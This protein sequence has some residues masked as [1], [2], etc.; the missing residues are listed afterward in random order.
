MSGILI[1]VDTRSDS[2]KQDLA[3]L[4]KNLA[5]LIRQAGR[6]QVALDKVQATGFKNVNKELS[7]GLKAF[8][9]FNTT[10]KRSLDATT[11]SSDNLASSL[12]TVRN[13]VLSMGAALAGLAGVSYFNRMAD[14]LTN[15]QNRLKLVTDGTDDLIRSQQR[16]YKLSVDTR[17]SFAGTANAFVDFTKSLEGTG[18]SQ[19]KVLSVV[20]T[21]QQASAL[22]GPLS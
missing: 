11:K 10:G 5:T 6:S 15:V 17:A 12:S 1:D 13:L 21:I 14:D 16:L 19:A 2:A 3:E 9:N 18:E 20:R 8:N 4:N 7:S 22:S